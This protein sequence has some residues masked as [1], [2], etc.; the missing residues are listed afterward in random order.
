MT[1]A[2]TIAAIA[3]A[4]LTWWFATGAVLW[5]GRAAND[6]HETAM[7]ALAVPAVLALLLIVAIRDELTVIAAIAGFSAAVA[8]WAWHEAAFLFGHL[9][10]PRR[11]PCPH[12][13]SHRQ[14]FGFAF[15]AMRDHEIA[16][17]AT[18]GLLALL[19]WGAANTVALQTF[20]VLWLCRLAAKLCIF[21]GVP[22][23]AHNLMPERLAH[24]KSYFGEGRPGTAFAFAMAGMGAALAVLVMSAMT[25]ETSGGLVGTVLLA[26]LLSLAIIEHA[27]MVLPVRDEKLWKWAAPHADAVE[28]AGTCAFLGRMPNARKL[29]GVALEARAVVPSRRAT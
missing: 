21:E 15:A 18:L 2:L 13:A 16:L 27:F 6:W 26:T 23:M 1:V 24:L 5:L 7:L 10:G 8:V 22:A 11:A 4:A 3:I 20:A 28:G 29:Q 19:T 9:L 12:G 25:A 14:R 17:A